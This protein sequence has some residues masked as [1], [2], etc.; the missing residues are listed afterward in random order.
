MIPYYEINFEYYL[1]KNVKNEYNWFYDEEQN[2]QLLNIMIFSM[3]LRGLHYKMLN[4][5]I[6]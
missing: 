6:S 1:L 2:C 3:Q 5:R 4:D